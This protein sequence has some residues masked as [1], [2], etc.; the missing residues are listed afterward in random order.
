MRFLWGKCRGERLISLK[1][2]PFFY[3]PRPRG[4]RPLLG[5]EWALEGRRR[6]TRQVLLRCFSEFQ[7]LESLAENL[8][9]LRLMGKRRGASITPQARATFP[10]KPPLMQHLPRCTRWRADQKSLHNLVSKL[11]TQSQR[12]LEYACCSSWMA[13]RLLCLWD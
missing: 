13:P 10:K 2:A 3:L 8:M 9:T 5:P 4:G 7:G 6:G 11:V 12:E 1:T